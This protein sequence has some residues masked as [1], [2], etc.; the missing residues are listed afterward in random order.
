MAL[1]ERATRSNSIAGR[2]QNNHG[3]PERTPEYL[4]PPAAPQQDHVKKQKPASLN[5]EHKTSDGS[6]AASPTSLCVTMA[7]LHYPNGGGHF[8]PS[9]CFLVLSANRKTFT[10]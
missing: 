4:L 8:V 9:A 5:N 1:L 7:M 10:N 6:A 3:D 2:H